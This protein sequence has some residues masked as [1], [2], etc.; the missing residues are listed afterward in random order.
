MLK[1]YVLFMK[2]RADL[3]HFANRTLQFRHKITAFFSIVQ[4]FLLFFLFLRIFINISLA[5]SKFLLY[6][7]RRFAA[8]ENAKHSK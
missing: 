3:G 7:C 5:H 8:K 2:L 6:L 1:Q 4:I